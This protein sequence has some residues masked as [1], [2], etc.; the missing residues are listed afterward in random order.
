MVE[1]IEDAPCQRD[2]GEVSVSA[3]DW[4]TSPPFLKLFTLS[5]VLT[6]VFNILPEINDCCKTV[7]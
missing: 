6:V 3:S 1:D 5:W 7:C 2:K 4:N